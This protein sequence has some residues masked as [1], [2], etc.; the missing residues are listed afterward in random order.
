MLTLR[1]KRICDS[2]AQLTTYGSVA[3][4][5][6]RSGEWSMSSLLIMTI[7]WSTCSDGTSNSWYWKKGVVPTELEKSRWRIKIRYI[8]LELYHVNTKI[9]VI[10]FLLRSRCLICMQYLFLPQAQVNQ[11]PPLFFASCGTQFIEK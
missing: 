11:T 4:P 6:G 7:S 5:N 3:S 10:F 9:F 8:S 1:Y 2:N